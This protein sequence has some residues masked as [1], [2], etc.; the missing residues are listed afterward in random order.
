MKDKTIELTQK[1][2][3][4]KTMAKNA[5]KKAVNNVKTN[6]SEAKE[7]FQ[8]AVSILQ[9]VGQKNVFHKNKARRLISRLTKKMKG[10]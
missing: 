6:D 1:N 4:Y 2:R 3:K 10:N 5:M 9:K 8:N 7:N